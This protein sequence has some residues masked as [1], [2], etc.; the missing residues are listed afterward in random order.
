MEIMESMISN[1]GFPI[2]CV[3][4]C[5]YFIN[6]IVKQNMQN[7]KDREDRLYTEIGKFGV[8]LDKFNDTLSSIDKRLAIL[9][10]KVER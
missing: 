4:A 3:C 2:A 6:N 9:E 5:G 7:S 1:L 8:T 10:N